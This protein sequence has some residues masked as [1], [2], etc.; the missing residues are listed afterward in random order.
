MSKQYDL[1]VV[2]GG[3]A[4]SSAAWRA[5][6]GGARVLC[7]DKAEFP[8]EKAC[9]DGL[10][11]R[12]VAHI[13]N[14][15]LQSELAG[16]YKI[17]SVKFFGNSTWQMRCPRRPGLP[18]YARVASRLELDEMLLNH[19][20]K[21]G[22]E[23]WQSAEVVRPVMDDGRVTGVDVRRANNREERVGA[24][25]VIAAD[26]AHSPMKKAMALKSRVAGTIAIAAR[27]EMDCDRPE[28]PSFE[29]H[30]PLSFRS[31]RIPG[32]GWVFP[33]GGRRV[34]IG[35]GYTTAYRR[36]KDIN[37][38][39][40]LEDFMRELPAEWKLPQAAQLRKARAIQAW[41][42]P[43]G[44]N[45]WPPSRPGLLLAGD[46]LGAAK[47]FTGAGISKALESGI[48]AAETAV[49]AL[50]S[51]NPADL[52]RYDKQLRSR[53]AFQYRMARIGHSIGGYPYMVGT[54][55]ALF[56]HHPFRWALVRALYG[57]EGGRCY[58][59]EFSDARLDSYV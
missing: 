4:G 23:V 10:T 16:F 44:F 33:M 41:R 35:V 45:S 3:P 17:D 30:M 21:R 27:A 29:I 50:G 52:S 51:A 43:M 34:N 49:H 53:W 42:L 48:L 54:A 2:G 8:R 37:I 38:V 14:M 9:G 32:Y 28:D 57:R 58:T 22:A 7:V 31:H 24:D 40:L 15:G 11:P 25:I 1:I 12:A 36:W 5:A 13:A 39:G 55:F 47:P 56:D 18:D 20:A 19:A 59:N 6:S 46:A 26:G